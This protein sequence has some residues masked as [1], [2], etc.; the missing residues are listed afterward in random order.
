MTEKSTMTRDDIIRM[1]REWLPKAYRDGDKG[2]AP[3]FTKHNME[4]AFIAGA[5][6]EREACAKVCNESAKNYYPIFPEASGACIHLSMAILA[7]GKE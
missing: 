4:A 1:A 2:D 6:A 7:R 3:R 5:E